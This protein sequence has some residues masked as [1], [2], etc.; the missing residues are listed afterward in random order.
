MYR[1][2]NQ[3]ATFSNP[4]MINV[5]PPIATRGLRIVSNIVTQLQEI[6]IK[7]AMSSPGRVCLSDK[8]QRN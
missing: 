3:V 2:L 1:P 7:L 5:K 6:R 4:T 8:L